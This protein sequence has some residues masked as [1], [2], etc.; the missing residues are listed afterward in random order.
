MWLRIAAASNAKDQD[1]L[2]Y[3]IQY[4]PMAP[5]VCLDHVNR[6][7]AGF[8]VACLGGHLKIGRSEWIGRGRDMEANGQM[9]NQDIEMFVA[10]DRTCGVNVKERAEMMWENVRRR[11]SDQGTG[12]R[13]NH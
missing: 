9:S 11:S 3:E 12:D 13:R 6:L 4:H 1:K 2:E 8:N 7:S 10:V 5:Q